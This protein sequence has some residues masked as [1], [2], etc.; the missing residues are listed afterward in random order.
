MSRRPARPWTWSPRARATAPRPAPAGGWRAGD[1]GVIIRAAVC[2][3]P[4]LLAT[5]VTGQTAVVPELREACE[6]AVAW[7][8]AAA[9]LAVTVVG[10]AAA[11]ASWPTDG[12]P[13]LSMHA[14][15]LN[16]RARPAGTDP[17][18]VDPA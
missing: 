13:D 14:P 2:P 5:G 18:G 16:R 17:L 1:G 10:P 11:T 9:P 15:A 4:P 7:L 3:S 12:V 6:A 8:L